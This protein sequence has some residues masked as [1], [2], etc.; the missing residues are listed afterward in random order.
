MSGT[1]VIKRAAQ[2]LSGLPGEAGLTPS[3]V[4]RLCAILFAGE[5]RT[6]PERRH[7]ETDRPVRQCGAEWLYVEFGEA[8]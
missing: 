3:G 8:D 5:R 6:L 2:F 4:D 1:E 7:F